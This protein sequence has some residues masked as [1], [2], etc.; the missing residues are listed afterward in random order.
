LAERGA[1][2]RENCAITGLE[3]GPNGAV[4][5]AITPEGVIPCK[6]LVIAGGTATPAIVEMATGRSGFP[7]DEVTGLL[8]ETPAAPLASGFDMVLW[9]PDETGFHMR[10][11]PGGGLLLGADDVDA[12]IRADPSDESLAAGHKTLIDR[13]L[14]WMPE[15]RKIDLHRGATHRIG[16]R[17][18]PTDGHSILGPLK[19][20]PGVYVAVT[21]SGVTLALAIAELL[22]EEITTSKIPAALGPFRPDRFGF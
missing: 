16:R 6:H 22:A 9:S 11:T 4:R 21:H 13:A 8:V 17:A 5:A 10:R 19:D 14:D 12:Q 7:V 3:R 1:I 2:L 20:T 15:L 18:V